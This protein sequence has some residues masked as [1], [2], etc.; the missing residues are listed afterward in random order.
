M[1]PHSPKTGSTAPSFL[2][3]K[4]LPDRA[5]SQQT[6]CEPLH[7]PTTHVQ[8][9]FGGGGAFSRLVLIGKRKGG[10]PDAPSSPTCTLGTA[11]H[12][13]LAIQASS[14]GGGKEGANGARAPSIEFAS[15]NNPIC[16][17]IEINKTR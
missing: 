14:S 5:D 4:R 8:C 2:K 7:T 16:I 13:V 3:K 6:P 12:E 17:T 15:H 1:S 9:S 11:G 10:A